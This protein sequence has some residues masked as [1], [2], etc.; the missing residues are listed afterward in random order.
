M[1]R[2]SSSPEAYREAVEGEQR[3][4]LEAIR[5]AIFEAAPDVEEGMEHGMLDYRD[6]ANLG[7]QKHYVSLYVLPAALD[8]HR[9]H[10][11]GVDSGRSCLRFR[12]LDQVDPR[13][14][15][16]LLKDVRKTRRADHR[17]KK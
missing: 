5:A 12:R 3:A 4:L 8:R 2:D 14:L 17:A 6:L 15:R 10:F 7:A 9:D 11:P 1:Q 16:A 13:R